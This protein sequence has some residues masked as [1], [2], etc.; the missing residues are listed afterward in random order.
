LLPTANQSHA[1]LA[2]KKT[3]KRKQ[4]IDDLLES[5]EF[6]RFQS[7]QMADLFRVNPR[8][9]T[10]GRAA[11][12]ANWIS[13]AIEQNR[14]F[15]EVTHDLLTATGDSNKVPPA[16]YYAALDTTESTIE[17][18]A[19]IFM[20][21]RIQC[22]KCHNHPFENW[23][24]DDYYQ[25]GAVF[26]RIQRAE[27]MIQMSDSG[28][29]EHPR[30]GEIMKPWGGGTNEDRRTKFADWLTSSEN[31][32]FAR[33]IVNRI[34]AHLLGK[35]IVE[36]VDDFRSSN[37]PSNVPL[38]DA[39]AADLVSSD[40]D[41]RHI[42]RA[43]CN[44][45]VYQRQTQTNEF[46]EDDEDNFSHSKVRLLSAEQLND[47]IA[48]MTKSAPTANEIPKTIERLKKKETELISETDS[49]LAQWK[50]KAETELQSS[51]LWE[52]SHWSS[53]FFLGESVEAA[54]STRFIE[55]DL[56]SLDSS[57][58]NWTQRTE[59]KNGQRIQFKEQE[60]GTRYLYQTIWV[61]GVGELKFH[62]RAS[63]GVQARCNGE[64]FFDQKKIGRDAKTQYGTAK[65]SAGLNHFLFKIVN[66]GGNFHFTARV[67][68]LH[69]TPIKEVKQSDWPGYV[70]DLIVQSTNDQTSDERERLRHFHQSINK[71]LTE[72]RHQL[73]E[74]D[75][76][77]ATQRPWPEQTSFLK[78][79]GQP[80]RISPCACERSGEPTLEQA[81]Q[82]LNGQHVFQQ[83]NTSDKAYTA[84]NDEQLI[85][86]LY[87]GA[88]SRFPNEEESTKTRIYLANTVSRQEAI[89]DIIWALVN[90]Q[91]FMFQH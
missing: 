66:G 88:Y 53:P 84:L 87:L 49:K 77:L 78:A 67:A 26:T 91:E 19:Q 3:E 28:E 13:E 12:F 69:G 33:V 85:E 51:D 52:G 22:A 42:F 2:S 68:E 38:L 83:I 9:L 72:L 71:E 41:R 50:A 20:G 57:K 37:P 62:F 44:S 31:P 8:T 61:S 86:T 89:Q 7:L 24:Q 23:T 32:F 25:I 58:I 45:Q 14:P 81:L 75:L 74:Q 90:T 21:S 70:N 56:I 79:F 18:T 46:N 34:W 64:V 76:L 10:D 35:G 39:L 17:T 48:Y 29:M 27:G 47:A 60:I 1:F 4:L 40:F 73:A 65:V 16:N 59:W 82:I 36:P 30:T 63:N 43:I 80:E 55:E 6:S 5:R 11:L 15:D 54:Y